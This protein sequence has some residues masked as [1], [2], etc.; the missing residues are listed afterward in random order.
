MIEK[1]AHRVAAGM[2]LLTSRSCASSC[3]RCR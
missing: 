2:V 3:P 1:G